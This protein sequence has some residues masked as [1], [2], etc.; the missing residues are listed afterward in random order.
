MTAAQQSHESHQSYRERPPAGPLADRLA[1]VWVQQVPA[2]APPLTHRTVPNGSV[3]I[4]AKLGSAVQVTGPRLA[5]TVT[6]VTP[7]TTIVGVRIRPGLAYPLLG[8]PASELAGRQVDLADL[9]GREAERLAEQLAA[10]ETAGEAARRLEA[11]FAPAA[12]AEADPLVLAAV[13]LLS[14]WRAASVAEAAA[15]LGVSTRHLRRR[16]LREV[17]YSA[18]TLHRVLRFQGFLAL[19]GSSGTQGRGASGLARLAAAAGYADQAHLTRESGQLAGLPPAAFLAERAGICGPT[20]DHTT[21]F[22][23]LLAARAR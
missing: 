20:H 22:Q 21:S 13:E 8:T 7:G 17:G 10:A 15:T 5:P 14:P 18:K 11:A 19:A 4:H 2:G 9:W 1:C 6:T 16:S 3:E 23:P 12:G